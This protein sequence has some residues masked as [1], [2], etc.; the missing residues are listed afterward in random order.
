MGATRKNVITGIHPKI[1]LKVMLK[2]LTLIARNTIINWK[3]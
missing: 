3:I 1:S 2:A